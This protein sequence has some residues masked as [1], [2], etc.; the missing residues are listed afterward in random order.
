MTIKLTAAEYSLKRYR[1]P[2][3]LLEMRYRDMR[4]RVNGKPKRTGME[5][6]PENCIWKG[7]ELAPRAEFIAWA[8]ADPEFLRLFAE[9]EANGY[10]RRY[11]PSAH[12]IDRSR[13]YTLDNIE[14]QVH[15]DKSR[16]HLA[17]GVATK[18]AKKA[19]LTS[20]V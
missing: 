20:A 10:Q 16:R 4:D 13:G 15:L 9:W 6:T 7:M 19:A 17:Q 3:G 5:K 2:K 8:L 11:S 14:W 18:A 1:T 12:R